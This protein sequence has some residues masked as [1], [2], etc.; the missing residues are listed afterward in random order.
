MLI[1]ARVALIEQSSPLAR[2]P[3]PLP[4][5]ACQSRGIRVFTDKPQLMG[6]RVP[7]I[8]AMGDFQRPDKPLEAITPFELLP[9]LAR[10]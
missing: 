5:F 10:P 3:P 9:C 6:M 7:A 8:L 2:R 4:H 1:K